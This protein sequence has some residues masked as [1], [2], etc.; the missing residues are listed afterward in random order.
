[1]VRTTVAPKKYTSTGSPVVRRQ[2]N[3]HGCAAEKN[4][5]AQSR[6][7][8]LDDHGLQGIQRRA[9][10]RCRR[11]HQTSS[12]LGQDPGVEETTIFVGSLVTRIELTS[13]H[14]AA[15]YISTE[16]RRWLLELE[17]TEGAGRGRCSTLRVSG[18]STPLIAETGQA[19]KDYYASV[20]TNELDHVLCVL[21]LQL[22]GSNDSDPGCLGF[23]QRKPGSCSRDKLL[24]HVVASILAG[25][26][27]AETSTSS[28]FTVPKEYLVFLLVALTNITVSS[29]FQ[30]P[31]I[32][33]TNLIN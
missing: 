31:F 33:L 17:S 11:G 26:R 3:L 28:D 2:D 4:R 6:K 15:A 30:I 20:R 14:G 5:F 16:W 18:S 32:G 1:M 25:G 13:T 22:M 19:A 29:W 23:G 27:I 24:T 7:R 8:A 12:P 10:N 9:A 21:A